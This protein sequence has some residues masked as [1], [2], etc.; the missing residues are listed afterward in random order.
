MHPRRVAVTGMGI[1]S[2]LGRITA[3]FGDA[4]RQGR[5]GIAEISL[6]DPAQLRCRWGGEIRGYDPLEHF[7]PQAE[8]YL[9]RFAQLA[10]VAAREAIRDASP[11]WTE[12]LRACTAVVTGTSIGGQSTQ[13]EGFR[14]LY[15]EGEARVHPLSLPRS[16]ANAG[17]GHIAMEH[18]LRGP[19]FTLSTACASGSHAIGH[20]F[21][22]VRSG[23]ADAA[24]VGGS[25]AP[26]SLGNYRAWEALKALAPD[27]CRPFSRDRRGTVLS[28]AGAMLFL[29][30][31][32]AALAR[33]AAVHG[34]IVGF[35]MSADAHHLTHPSAAGAAEAMRAALRDADLQPERVG[36]VNA[37]GTGTAVNDRTET[38]AI[39]EVFGSHASRLAVSS[40][41]SM[42]G[43]G[44]G[45][46]GAM[47][48]IATLLALRDS[49]L[50]PTINYSEPD[51]EC[52]L[53]VVPNQ[54]RA[55]ETEYA[56]SNSFGFGGLNAVL[57]FRRYPC[58]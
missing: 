25:E 21:W 26:F 44:Q 24:V 47:E 31:L 45:A 56:L 51:P 11:A 6:L 28:E 46:G 52:D 42:H 22:L 9:D 23:V 57:A 55:A 20:A 4:L 39:R 7:S 40:T 35:G 34:E 13:D 32:D 2:P 1:I 12:A 53:D 27:A 50:P 37:H 19:A 14:K 18:G 8:L 3:E 36:Y 54:P 15:G 10:L 16:M 58:N 30:P 17:A 41:K 29:E 48:A 49:V 38:A 43:H 33:G 5:S